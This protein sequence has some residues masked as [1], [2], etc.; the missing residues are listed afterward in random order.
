LSTVRIHR[1]IG[2]SFSASLFRHRL[3]AISRG[4]AN[5]RF[6]AQGLYLPGMYSNELGDVVVAVDCSG[7][8]GERELSLF[9]E[10]VN[11]VLSSFDTTVTLLYHDSCI[12]KVVEHCSTD[13]PLKLEPVGGGGT[14][15]VC[16]FEWLEKSG[17][18]PSCVVALT[19]LATEFGSAP[20][21]PVLWAVV[22]GNKEMP[23]FGRVVEIDS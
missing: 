7:S 14:S 18:S 13:G 10:E 15:H 22:G 5:R 21:T 23:P 8:V 12:Q 9:A 1:L 11:A 17:G 20:D 3:G 6:I 19:D 16:V 4:L 2:V